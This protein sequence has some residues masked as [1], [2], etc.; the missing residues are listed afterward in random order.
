MLVSLSKAKFSSILEL[1]EPARS[2]FRNKSPERS[3][4][5]S[6]SR[7]RRTAE[8]NTPAEN[9]TISISLDEINDSLNGNKILG[10]KRL[11]SFF[12]DIFTCYLFRLWITKKTGTK[13]RSKMA[14]I[15]WSCC[16]DFPIEN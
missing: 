10:E 6:R 4:T 12:N 8:E 14:N 1:K 11:Y 7:I 16:Y 5:R 3:Q 15:G 9:R 2:H 13:P